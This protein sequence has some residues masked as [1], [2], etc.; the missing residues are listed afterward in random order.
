MSI[1]RKV[2]AI[3]LSIVLILLSI[4]I[5][6]FAVTN[7]DTEINVEDLDKIYAIFTED[8]ILNI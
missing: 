5:N 3:F 7:K 2:S 6:S 8:I 1:M 4:T